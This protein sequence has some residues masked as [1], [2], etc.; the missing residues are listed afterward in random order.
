ML[1]VFFNHTPVSP[2][3]LLACKWNNRFYVLELLTI[4][5]VAVAEA[6][7]ALIYASIL[8]FHK[9]DKPGIATMS[10]EGNCC[11]NQI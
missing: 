2:H 7:L 4:A 1:S 6:S 9:P 3:N 11:R 8:P 10:L 5:V